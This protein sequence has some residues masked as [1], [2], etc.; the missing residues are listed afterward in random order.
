M[1]E[2]TSCMKERGKERVR[3]RS[4]REREG[5]DEGESGEGGKGHVGERRANLNSLGN[6]K[7]CESH[8]KQLTNITEDDLRCVLEDMRFW[9]K[10]DWDL[11]SRK[12]L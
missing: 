1:E 11:V 9:W 3:R 2:I 6:Y 7:N 5:E 4:Q 10:P 12:E 8:L